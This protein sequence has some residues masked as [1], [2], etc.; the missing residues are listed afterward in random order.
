MPEYPAAH[1]RV[2]PIPRRERRHHPARYRKLYPPF[3]G[4]GISGNPVRDPP[5]HIAGSRA[6]HDA[7]GL[8]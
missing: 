1:G 4:E 3:I 5:A 7:G 2:Q 8:S 6:L